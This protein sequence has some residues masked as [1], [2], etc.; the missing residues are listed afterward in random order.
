MESFK[1]NK[2]QRLLVGIGAIA[3]LGRAWFIWQGDPSEGRPGTA[4]LAGIVL[5]A[6]ALTRPRDG[7]EAL[8][9]VDY[10]RTDGRW[11]KIVGAIAAMIALALLVLASKMLDKAPAQMTKDLAY[12]ETR[13]S[14]PDAY[15]PARRPPVANPAQTD[16]GA[17]L[18][19]SDPG[20]CEMA[21]SLEKIFSQMARIDPDTSA[22]S[23]GRP[24]HV[25]G[26]QK[27][28][29]PSFEMKRDVTPDHKTIR[30]IANLSVPGIWH[31]LKV[32][33]LRSDFVLQSDVDERQI[34]FLEDPA[35]VRQTLNQF[36]FR[37]PPV[38]QSRPTTTDPETVVVVQIGL[39]A[40]GGGTALA[41][42][43]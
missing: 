40:V 2:W 17:A 9:G 7:E 13:F 20:S 8:P 12:W 15:I 14:P 30:V 27:S 21:P 24:I 22:A 3:C 1:P 39:K 6:I 26:Y 35:K 38:G 37:L 11:K 18:A 19:F 28:I 4:F 23:Q 33:S 32:S 16:L 42:W 34:R 31:G 10:L 29:L 43:T 41:C 25:D 5:A 36:G